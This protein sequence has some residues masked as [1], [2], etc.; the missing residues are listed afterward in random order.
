MATGAKAARDNHNLKQPRS[1]VVGGRAYAKRGRYM[2]FVVPALVVIFAVIVFPWLFT[3]YMSVHDWKITQT[4]SF[5]GLDNY[6]NLLTDRR[7]LESIGHT[8][9][10][11]VLAVILPIL[12][13]VASAVVFHQKFPWRGF[14]RAVFIMPM[15]ATPVAVALVWT[16][17]SRKRRS[18]SS[19]A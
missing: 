15:M 2:R 8:L 7:F 14:L 13:G 18:V 12:F 1:A 10:F 5:I 16:M 17:D 19:L 9:Y 11:T 4:Q 3:G 6:A